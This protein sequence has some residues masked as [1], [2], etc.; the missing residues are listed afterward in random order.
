MH[1]W[2]L[3]EDLKGHDGDDRTEWANDQLRHTGITA[4]LKRGAGNGL[5]RGEMSKAQVAE[6]AGNSERM[7]D[8][9]YKGIA[10]GTQRECDALWAVSPEAVG[11]G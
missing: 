8:D 6:W 2:G 5:K 4:I 9:H 10:K 3:E 1:K 7:I 11:V